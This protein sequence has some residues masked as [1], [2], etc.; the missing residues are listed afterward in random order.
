MLITIVTIPHDQQ[1]YETCGDWQWDKKGNLLITVSDMKNWR[2]NFLVA[3]HELIE[4]M[5]C[6]AR[7][8][9]QQ[10][11]DGFDLQYEAVRPPDDITSEPGDSPLAPY[12]KEHVFATKQ[13]REM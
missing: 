11:V 8:I 9:S 13:E 5:L 6:R 10:E 7:S 12:N 4:V 2:K 1:R 3:Y